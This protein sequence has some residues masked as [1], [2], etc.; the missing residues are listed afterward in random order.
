MGKPSKAVL[1]FMAKY[2]V[3]S[4]EI[5]EVRAGGAWAIKHAALE[6]VA[7]ENGVTFGLP[8]IIEGDGLNKN[9][10]ILVPAK[11]GERSDWSIGEASPANCKNAYYYAMAEKRARDRV[12]LKL[13]NSSGGIYSEEE[14]DDFR[15]Q[16]PHV[17]RP[18]DIVPQV[19]YDEHGEPID[20]IPRGDDRIERLPK[21]K[22]RADF[23]AA[24]HEL[25]QCKSPEALAD[26]GKANANRV[27]SYPSDWQEILRG[28]YIEHMTDL[29]SANG[30]AA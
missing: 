5:W 10:A 21:S 22:A 14:S 17:T 2:K 4:D 12:A 28:I 7:A 18:E 13:L 20:N 9:V 15:R 27:E 25:R 8:T 16:N 6:R 24:Q 29:R 26:W 30:K 3:D 11:M 1:E 19:E 23:A